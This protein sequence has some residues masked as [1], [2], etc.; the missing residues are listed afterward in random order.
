MKGSGFVVL[1]TSA[2][3]AIPSVARADMI[4]SVPA[5]LATGQG[6]VTSTGLAM[7]DDGTAMA[8]WTGSSGLG[9]ARWDGHGWLP[10]VALA[11]GAISASIALSDNGTCA[12]AAY[13]VGRQVVV[14]WWGSS[15]WSA[16]ETLSAHSDF[17]TGPTA[18]VDAD[19]SD[20]MVVWQHKVGTAN[21][22]QASRW[23]GGAWLAAQELAATGAQIPLPSVAMS[24]DGQAVMTFASPGM[25]GPEVGSRWWNG[26]VWSSAE[27]LSLGPSVGM[28]PAPSVAIADDASTAAAI[29]SVSL[30]GLSRVQ[31]ALHTA[32]GWTA[33][34]DLSTPGTEFGWPRVAVSGKGDSAVAIWG[35]SNVPVTTDVQTSVWN[36]VSWSSPTTVATS[37]ASFPQVAISPDGRNAAA[38]WNLSTGTV[39]SAAWG[40]DLWHSAT[41]LS[42]LSS[43]SSAAKVASGATAADLVVMWRTT[44]GTVQ[45]VVPARIPDPPTAVQASPSDAS[46]TAS[47]SAPRDDGGR[48]ITGYVATARPGGASCD[49]VDLSCTIIGLTNGVDYTVTVTATNAVGTSTESAPSQPVTPFAAPPAQPVIPSPSPTVPADV[50]TVTTVS[51]WPR[52]MRTNGARVRVRFAVS[53]AQGRTVLVQRK[54]SAWVTIRRVRLSPAVTARAS[55]R[56]GPGKYRLVIPKVSGATSLKTGVLRVRGRQG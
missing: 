2:V 1:M 21:T 16:P 8:V 19:C 45:A 11:P 18:V 13:E 35:P 6:N 12:V 7:A 3:L 47:W 52:R 4:W 32:T 40:D 51:G 56:L 15:G 14:N 25:A 22:V 17:F 27:Q 41:A 44:S 53:P 54:R 43:T 23:S 49:S 38:V 30:L 9:V 28:T 46:V 42:D 34:Q 31:A 5:S 36:G 48:P 10:P 26:S 39:A 33:P 29:W 55:V 20:A 50:T 37:A 24:D